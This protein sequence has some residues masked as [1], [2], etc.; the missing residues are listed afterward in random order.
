MKKHIRI[1]LA[2]IAV[3]MA[4]S[5]ELLPLQDTY[6]FDP[7]LDI[8]DP[9]AG[10]TAWDFINSEAA[11]RTNAEGGLIGD[12]F[13]YLKA[14]IEKAGYVDIYNQTETTDRTYLLLNNNAFTGGG[15]VIQLITGSATVAVGET[16]EQVM[17][18]VDTPEEMETLRK[19]LDYHIVL[20]YID[21]VPTL[22]EFG[23][24]YLFQ[25][26]I[27]GEDGLIAFRR[28]ERY[29]VDIN[30]SPAPLPTSATS[31][32]ETIRNYNYIFNNGIGHHLNDPVRNQPY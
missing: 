12:S 11:L 15:D 14:A 2:V 9:F 13:H 18:R 4:V 3:S 10:G 17:E 25:T 32:N 6:D 16:P 30:R 21:Q 28:D 26:R 8:N 31:Q 22:F 1:L 5:C 19:V 29:R 20:T 23:V 24:Q 7:Q 27:P